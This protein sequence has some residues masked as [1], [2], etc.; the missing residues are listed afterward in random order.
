MGKLIFMK[1]CIVIIFSLLSFCKIHDRS[2]CDII[3]KIITDKKV[4]QFLHR[5]L[6]TRKTL[7]VVNNELCDNLDTLIK[8]QKVVTINKNR[9]SSNDNYIEIRSIKKN[10]SG[11]EIFI[12]YPIEGATFIVKVDN[13]NKIT[14]I[15]IVEK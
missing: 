7:Y 12:D 10:D 15:K 5:E 3:E 1:N 6:D 14:G 2:Q 4:E 13:T 9:I 11:M 8:N